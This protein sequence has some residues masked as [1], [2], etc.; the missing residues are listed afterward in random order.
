MG[1]LYRSS[2]LEW[3]I[4]LNMNVLSMAS[5]QSVFNERSVT[6]VLDHVVSACSGVHAPLEKI[7]HRLRSSRA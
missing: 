2:D 3:A 7:D 5:H 1:M 6:C 4:L